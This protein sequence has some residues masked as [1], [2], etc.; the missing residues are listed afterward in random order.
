MSRFR[1]ILGLI[2]GAMMIVSSAAHSALGWK[3]LKAALAQSQAPADLIGSLGI[4]WQFA[5]I[6]MLA[7]GVILVVTF[8]RRLKGAAVPMMPA[9]VIGATYL[10]FSAWALLVSAFDPFF[11]I[12][13]VPGILTLIASVGAH[14]R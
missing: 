9:I 13:V 4:G 14:D 5:G 10:L 8:A 2:A 6:A 1:S 12:F 7:F 3:Q 11:S